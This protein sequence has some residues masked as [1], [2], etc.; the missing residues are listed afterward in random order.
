MTGSLKDNIFGGVTAAVVAL[1]LALAFGVASGAGPLAGLYGAILVGFFAALFGGTP[2]QI[3]G[4][5]GPMTIVMAAII[6]EFAVYSPEQG[7]ALAFTVVFLGGIFQILTGL[8]RLG[9]YITLVPY[10]VISGFMS[11]IGVLIIILQLAPL[12][13]HPG[14]GDPVAAI[15]ALPGI[16]MNPEIPALA[17]GGLTLLVLFVWPDAFKKW[18]PAPLAALFVGTIALMLLFPG[19]SIAKIG[20]V[21]SGLPDFYMPVFE[22]AM[23]QVIVT[24]AIMLAALGCIDS[25]LTSL[26]AD[27]MTRTRHKSDKELIGQGIGNMVAG[28]FGGLPGAGATMRTVININSGGTNNT[29]GMIHAGVLAAILLGAGGLV[30]NIPLAVLAG[31]LFKVGIDIIDW[32]FIFRLHK[33][34]LFPV[35]LMLGVLGM[36]VFV[37]LMVA[38][39]VGVFVTNIVTIDRLTRLQIDGLQYSDGSNDNPKLAR[40][41]PLLSS[42]SGSVLLIKFSGP[43]SFG[44]AHSIPGTVAGFSSHKAVVIDFLGAQVIGITSCLAIEKIIHQEVAAGRQV[45]LSGLHE[46][47]REKFAQLGMLD[48]VADNHKSAN[49]LEAIE[50]ACSDLEIS[51]IAKQVDG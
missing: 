38:V 7:L 45:Y 32:Q 36:T 50:Q 25:L 46:E 21:P 6:A 3:S 19:S 5:T 18:L 31:I 15:M 24:K 29:S 2:T 8:L 28:L 33:L 41:M 20:K 16:I 27:N 23:M 4:P 10:P 39:F 51:S 37:D 42:L 17:V 12:F 44:V 26:V 30:E 47:T 34:P 49:A 48:A 9:K 22:L 14:G 11:G 1:P 43:L 40:E 35:A 13:G